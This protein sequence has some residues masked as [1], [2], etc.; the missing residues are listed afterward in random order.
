MAA[1]YTY[2]QEPVL[3]WS[4]S[5]NDQRFGRLLLIFLLV[6]GISCVIIP[7]LHVSKPERQ[8]LD[9][10]SP[11]L[12]KLIVQQKKKPPPPPK[13]KKKKAP[14]ADQKK[15]AAA[16]KKAQSSGLLA[17]SKELSSL[18][19][20]FDMSMLSN[21]VPLS[22]SSKE[23]TSSGKTSLSSEARKDS[24]GINTKGLSRSTGNTQLAKRKSSEVSSNI[25]GSGGVGRDRTNNSAIRG[26][27]EI[28][29]VFQKNKGAIFSLYNRALRK[30]PGLQGKVVLELTISASGTVTKVRIISSELNNKDLENKLIARIKLFRFAPRKVDEVKVTYPIDFLPS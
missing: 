16:K 25:Q 21:S 26:E 12:A 1:A 27:E 11:R 22:K 19:D 18:Q 4:Q 30:D 3:P 23:R 5:E 28:E 6:V 7:I 9:K 2:W 29:L 15:T 8:Q 20:S 13:I 17:M 24:G 14:R 10:V